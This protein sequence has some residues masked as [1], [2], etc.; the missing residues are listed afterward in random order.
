MFGHFF[1]RWF[2]HASGV[3]ELALS[4]QRPSS[5]VVDEGR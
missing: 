4:E 5:P 3:G 2:I 1:C